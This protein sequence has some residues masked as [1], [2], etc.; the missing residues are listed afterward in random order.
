MPIADYLI[1]SPRLEG[2]FTTFVAA[3]CGYNG[4]VVTNRFAGDVEKMGTLQTEP[5]NATT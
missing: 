3:Y 5:L 1:D 4:P 2:A